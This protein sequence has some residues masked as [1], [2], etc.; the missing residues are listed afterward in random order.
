M[1]MLSKPKSTWTGI[2]FNLK[3]ASDLNFGTLLI[4][5]RASHED[6]LD[7]TEL[8]SLVQTKIMTVDRWF[9]DAY[10]NTEWPARYVPLI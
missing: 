2:H 3:G 5:S 10:T 9:F 1:L 7:P 6:Q 4:N 8:R